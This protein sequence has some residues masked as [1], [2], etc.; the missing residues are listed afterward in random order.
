MR[1]PRVIWRSMRRLA[2]RWLQSGPPSHSIA[3]FDPQEFSD[4]IRSGRKQ[5]LETLAR[6]LSEHHDRSPGSAASKSTRTKSG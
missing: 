3:V 1:H 2:N 4:L 5:D 6:R